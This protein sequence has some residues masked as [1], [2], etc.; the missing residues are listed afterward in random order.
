MFCVL[1][2]ITGSGF[3]ET[4]LFKLFIKKLCQ[5]ISWSEDA[6]PSAETNNENSTDTASCISEKLNVSNLHILLRENLL[7]LF[8]QVPAPVDGNKESK[9]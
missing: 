7:E 1:V 8:T 9:R 4:S 3:H 6:I 2:F 5:E